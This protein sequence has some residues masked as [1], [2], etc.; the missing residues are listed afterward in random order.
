MILRARHHG[1]DHLEIARLEDIER[2]CRAR[3]Q[4]CAAKRKNGNPRR[5]IGWT[6]IAIRECQVGLSPLGGRKNQLNRVDDSL[7]RPSATNGSFGPH[8][9]KNCKSC[10]RAASS[11]HW[12]S[13]LTRSSRRSR[14]SCLSPLAPKADRKV[15]TRLMIAGIFR[16]PLAQRREF[17]GVCALFP[18][19]KSLLQ[20]S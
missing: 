5:Q 12:R 10:L 9:S 1:V 15:K 13:I 14:A 18:R 20:Y 8:A 7:R 2:Q 3:Q 4:N 16:E 6:P 11:F 17:A 19:A